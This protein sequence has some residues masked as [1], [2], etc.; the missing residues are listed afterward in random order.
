M[1]YVKTKD[2]CITEGNFKLGTTI[3]TVWDEETITKE[4]SANTI[5]ELCEELV[6]IPLK[7]SSIDENV[8]YGLE[9]GYYCRSK[10][11]QYYN[12]SLKNKELVQN[13]LK[14][15][16]LYGAIW[17]TGEHGEPIL[18]SVAKMNNEGKLEL[19]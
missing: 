15:Y 4:N 14:Y 1:K 17:T 9:H 10:G 7:L 16:A 18:K 12:F 6:E 11:D 3:L 2:G 5:E 8:I 13:K 19:L